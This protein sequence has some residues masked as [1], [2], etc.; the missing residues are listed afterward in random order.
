M[1]ALSSVPVECSDDSVLHRP[2]LVN[3]VVRHLVIR[4]EGTYIDGTLGC[5]GH[6]GAILKSLQG[7]G[8]LLGIDRDEEALSVARQR[9][10]DFGGRC[11]F[12]HGSYEDL[13]A[14]CDL[15]G[16]REVDGILL[17]LGISSLQVDSAERGFSFSK[18][19]LLDMR[20]NQQE[21]TTAADLIRQGSERD[22]ERILKEYGEE[23]FASRI[24]RAIV[25]R[26]REKTITTT[27]EL[28]DLVAR[29]IPRK[30][31]PRRIHPAT[32]TFQALRI[33]VNRELE[34]LNHF[35][36]KAPHFLAP[37]GR[38]T[39]LSYHSLEDRMVKISFLQGEREGVLK[40]VAKKP[41]FSSEEECL[42]NPRARS[43]RLRVA[44]KRR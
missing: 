15:L 19:A 3:E 31:W 16:T 11:L 40:R 36:T 33:Q 25:Q 4:G 5:G 35:L 8:R 10:S 7:K 12:L 14:A 44:E 13:G 42:E 6:A 24:A 32:R 39:I 26:R 29:T 1:I 34:K 23:P 38:L 27:T 2:V 22:L 17:D 20:M 9:L 41:T 28:A 30:A 21:R 37:G 43:A 18:E